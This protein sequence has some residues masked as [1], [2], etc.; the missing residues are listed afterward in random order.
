MSHMLTRRETNETVGEKSISGEI[1]PLDEAF[2][3]RLA[4]TYGTLSAKLR[5]AADYVVAN[6]V[7]TATRSLRAVSGESGVAPA[8]FSRLAKALGYT[9]FE[10]LR[11]VLRASIGRKIDSFSSRAEQ[12]HSEHGNSGADFTP[13][14]MNACLNNISALGADIDHKQLNTT[15][16]KLDKSRSVVLF[17]V[18]GSAGIVDYMAYMAGFLKDNWTLAGRGGASLG[19]KLVMMDERDALI[20][21]TK[22]PFAP[23]VLMAAKLARQRGIYVVVI[24]DTHTCEALRHASSGFIV[25][26][27][28]PHFFSSY[29]ATVFLVETIIGKLAAQADASASERIAII[30]QLNRR[31]QEAGTDHNP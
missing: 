21:I 14:H 2:D 13:A 23:R 1:R 19:S 16:A 7:N 18:L 28:S 9:N 27:K 6:P 24:S 10:A 20:I 15:V 29:T 11:D 25:P 12:L 22:P 4:G 26:T 3:V 31:L 5:Q 30:E 8:T 17:G